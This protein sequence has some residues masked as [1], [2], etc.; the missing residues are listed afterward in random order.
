MHKAILSIAL[1]A[2]AGLA[3]GCSSPAPDAEV[4]KVQAQ[5]EA[6]NN[7]PAAQSAQAAPSDP[8]IIYPGAKKKHTGP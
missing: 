8:S 4:T 1:L 5:H 7:S 3:V 2:I 6:E